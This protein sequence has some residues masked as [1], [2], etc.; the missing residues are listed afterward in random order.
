MAQLGKNISIFIRKCALKF[1]Q[2][3]FETMNYFLDVILPK[4]GYIISWAQCKMK[5][6]SLLFKSYWSSCCGL[7]ETNPTSIHEDVG[8]VPALAQW[9]RDLA[10]P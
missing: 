9:I 1:K 8:L 4:T 3:I 7:V 6:Q 10:L 2:W 5:M